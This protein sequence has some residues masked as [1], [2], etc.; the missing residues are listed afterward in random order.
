MVMD[1]KLIWFSVYKTR[2]VSTYL[3]NGIKSWTFESYHVAQRNL[4]RM[5]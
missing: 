3:K 2:R 1:V 4:K 5:I